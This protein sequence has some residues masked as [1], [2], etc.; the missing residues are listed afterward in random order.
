MSYFGLEPLWYC[1]PQPLSEQ[2]KSTIP[3]GSIDFPPSTVLIHML[4][5]TLISLSPLVPFLDMQ[6][7]LSRWVWLHTLK[8]DIG[9]DFIW[10]SSLSALHP[11]SVAT[12][13][14]TSADEQDKVSK[15]KHLTH[16]TCWPIPNFMS[17]RSIFCRI[18]TQYTSQTFPTDLWLRDVLCHGFP[19]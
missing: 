12:M 8:L 17:T 18:Y 1:I 9:E 16:R 13:Q 19:T 10:S 5:G 3:K 7:V 11:L 6:E 2:L 14:R 4:C 15:R